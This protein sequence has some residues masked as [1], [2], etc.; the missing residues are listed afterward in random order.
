MDL[1]SKAK[2]LNEEKTTPVKAWIDEKGFHI[3]PI[4]YK[5]NKKKNYE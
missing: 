3:K 4:K 1:E 2:P 5:N